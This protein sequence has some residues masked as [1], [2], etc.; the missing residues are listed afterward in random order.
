MCALFALCLGF[1][2]TLAA[3]A[4]QRQ[5]TIQPVGKAD[6]KQPARATVAAKQ[7]NAC[8]CID[9]APPDPHHP[10]TLTAE[11]LCDLLNCIG[12]GVTAQPQPTGFKSKLMAVNPNQAADVF[13]DNAWFPI[14]QGDVT[15]ANWRVVKARNYLW[16]DWA[17]VATTHLGFARSWSSGH[18]PKLQCHLARGELRDLDVLRHQVTSSLLQWETCR[19]VQ[20]Q[21]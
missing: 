1:G 15:I 19:S 5:D 2:C 14:G 17:G 9:R 18:N 16:R 21:R 11:Q 20:H 12:A 13:G 6:D 3:A 8:D 4:D 10:L 7:P